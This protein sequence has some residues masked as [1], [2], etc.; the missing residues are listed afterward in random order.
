VLC[1]RCNLTRDMISW[2][3]LSLPAMAKKAGYGLEHC[4]FDGYSMPTQQTHSTVLAITSRLKFNAEGRFFDN[5]VQ[6]V[7][8]AKAIMTAH[9]VI[10]KTLGV[11]NAYFA[12]GLNDEISQREAECKAVWPGIERE[13]G[14]GL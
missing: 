8:A 9:V 1:D 7:F 5:S 11:E 4:Y 13:C 3:K 2:S 10:L 14:K 6:G 12:L